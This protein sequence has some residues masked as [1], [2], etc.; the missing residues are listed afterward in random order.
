MKK[1]YIS[2]SKNSNYDDLLKLRSELKKFKDI[3]IIEYTGGAYSTKPLE[4]CDYCI[5]VPPNTAVYPTKLG[6]CDYCLSPVGKGQ[7]SEFEVIDHLGIDSCLFY[8]NTFYEYFNMWEI[9][10]AKDFN[11]WAKLYFDSCSKLTLE[12]FFGINSGIIKE[13]NNTSENIQNKKLLLLNNG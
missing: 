11:I 12:D 6:G 5:V 4:D 2:K 1:V 13:V 10:N 7:Y 9:D 3:E 8:K